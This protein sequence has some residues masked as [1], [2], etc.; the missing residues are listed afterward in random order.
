MQNENIE[1]AMHYMQNKYQRAMHWY[2]DSL[3][4]SYDL[5][6]SGTSE[7]YIWE[8]DI[9]CGIHGPMK[10]RAPQDWW[11]CVG[12]DG[13]GCCTLTAEDLYLLARG[14]PFIEDHPLLPIMYERAFRNEVPVLVRVTVRAVNIDDDE[15]AA[16]GYSKAPSSEV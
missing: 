9:Q 8:I 5:P 6:R 11:T 14:Q 3:H 10:Y 1:A 4:G 7:P 16:R 2:D 15:L 13:E 12:F